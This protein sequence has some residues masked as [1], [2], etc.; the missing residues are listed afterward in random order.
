MTEKQKRQEAGRLL[1]N[2]EP[3]I[4]GGRELQLVE[5]DLPASIRESSNAMFVPRGAARRPR[6]GIGAKKKTLNAGGSGGV[7]STLT[8]SASPEKGQDDFRRML[9]PGT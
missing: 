7:A 1:L 4:F 9:N 8:D 2:P 6:A 5:D 3:L